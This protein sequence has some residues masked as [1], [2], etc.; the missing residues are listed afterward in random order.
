VDVAH[1]WRHPAVPGVDLMRAHFVR[2]GFARHTHDSYAIGAVRSGFEDLLVGGEVHR[3]PPGAVVLLNPDV[4][5]TGRAVDAEG[6]SYRVFYPDIA[7]VREA[8]G[9]DRP[10]FREPVVHDAAA[11]AAAAIFRAHRAAESGDRLTSGTLLMSVLSQLWHG[12]GG[13]RRRAREP[14]G[15]RA[16]AAARDI[17]HERTVDPPSLGELAAEVGASQFALVRAFGARYGLPPHAYVNQLRVRLA[18]A[19][20]AAG[21]PVATVAV[22]VGFADQSHLTR[23]FRATVGVTPGRYRSKNVQ[24]R[25]R[26]GS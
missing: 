25:R 7:V 3:V 4:V 17:L 6:W 19:L 1:Y 14:A 23:H 8:T 24:D 20:L 15:D 16:V 2:H 22:T 11:A 5:H 13:G 9:S 26:P 21:E 10:W 18:R 12:Y